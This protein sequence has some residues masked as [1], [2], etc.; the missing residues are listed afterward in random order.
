MSIDYVSSIFDTSQCFL[1]H[2]KETMLLGD[3]QKADR[4]FRDLVSN[5]MKDIQIVDS[6]RTLN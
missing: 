1:V 4:M 6:Y 3:Y 5:R 2:D